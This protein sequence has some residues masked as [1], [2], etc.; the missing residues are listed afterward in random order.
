MRLL[1][2][3]MHGSWTTSFVQGRHEYVLPVTPGRDADGRGRAATWDWPASVVE[4]E[5]AALAQ[6]RFDAVV[7]QRPHEAELV[8][9]W[10]GVRPGVDVPAV[11]VEHDTPRGTAVD[12]RHP[13]A[14]RGDIPIVHVTHFNRL[15]WDNGV[16]PAHVIEHGVP[17]PGE[18]Y[19]GDRERLAVVVNHPVRRGR[20]VG[21][22]LIARLAVGGE[23][24]LEVYGM[25][26]RELA[27]A[28]PALAGHVHDDL[29][30]HRLHEAIGE[31]RAYLH[32][33]R[34]TSLGLALIEAM[35][36]GMPVLALATTEAPRA[37][38][39]SAGLVSSDLRELADRARRWMADPVEAR[40]VGAEARRHAL[41]AF[42]LDRFLREWDELLEE[43]GA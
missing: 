37:V 1:L 26:M 17:D 22:D 32:P 12:T 16:A 31:N 43:A 18:R 39:A 36:L 13:V 19:T 15:M 30:Q 34:W 29:P 24:G 21:C 3:H 40:E 11:Y 6:E 2:W 41:G 20:L 7:L 23:V 42:G 27:E 28:V 4:R 35:L 9:R 33:F 14:D 10:A 8:E 38:P 25:G 5:P